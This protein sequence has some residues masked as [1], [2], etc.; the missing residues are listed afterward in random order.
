MPERLAPV[1]DAD[2]TSRLSLTYY[3]VAQTLGSL[4]TNAA[5]QLRASRSRRTERRRPVLRIRD[6]VDAVRGSEPK[7]ANVQYIE[8]ARYVRVV[9]VAFACLAFAPGAVP[10]AQAFELPS[11][12]AV[13]EC[14]AL[15]APGRLHCTLEARLAGN[16]RLEWIDV[17]LIEVPPFAIALRGRL[18]GAEADVREPTLYRWSTA[19]VAKREGAGDVRIRVR[20]VACEAADKGPSRSENP[21]CIPITAQA[22]ASIRV[23]KPSK[24]GP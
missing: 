11:L 17:Q 7:Q 18:A 14:E 8:W 15:S 1:G 2:H 5:P 16:A 4:S 21:V 13:V 23:G 9:C 12:R 24:S 20:A 6:S 10:V 3:R 19:I 22:Q